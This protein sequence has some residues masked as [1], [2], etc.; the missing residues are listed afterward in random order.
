MATESSGPLIALA[1]NLAQ[2]LPR[3]DEGLWHWISNTL[4]FELAYRPTCKEHDAPFGFVA[5]AVFGRFQSAVLRGSRGAGKT[6]NLSIVHLLNSHFRPEFQTAHVGAALRQA[7][8]NYSYVRGYFQMPLFGRALAGDPT[9]TE[10]RWKNGARLQILPGTVGGTSGPHP[11]LACADEFDLMDWQVYQ[12]FVGMPQSNDRYQAQSIFT[13]AMVSNFGPLAR[14]IDEAPNRGMSVYTSCILDSL[15][16]C[17]TCQ[18]AENVKRGIKLEPPACPLWND[19]H[20]RARAATGHIALSDAIA[21]FRQTDESV[22]ATQYLCKAGSTNGLI[23]S[24]FDPA[25]AS[26]PGKTNVSPDV[27]YNPELPVILLV[28]DGWNPDPMVFLAANV[29]PNGDLWVFDEIY[30]TSCLY[31]EAITYI[32]SG[33]VNRL[34]GQEEDSWIWREVAFDERLGPRATGVTRRY[35]KPAAIYGGHSDNQLHAHL[36]K[37]GLSARVPTKTRVLDGIS[38]VRRMICDRQGHRSLVFSTRCR[39]AIR[40]FSHYHAKKLPT[41]EY[42]SEPADNTGGS[43]ADNAA[44]CVRNFAGFSLEGRGGRL[45]VY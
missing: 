35:K 17:P 19:C 42:G 18:D 37:L 30:L 40:E 34:T 12:Q 2:S 22:W 29:R 39:N 5:D 45:E 25:P 4:G 43:N 16:K 36:S 3:D 33:E 14:L 44:D 32:R 8:L 31:E 21:R 15:Q 26:P 24:T 13:S 41:G 38:E 9:M 23:Y 27:E 11:N 7:N 6:R 28:D 20:G 1:N 10:T